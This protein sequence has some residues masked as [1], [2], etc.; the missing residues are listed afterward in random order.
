[1]NRDTRWTYALLAG[2]FLLI[3]LSAY[4]LLTQGRELRSARE[5]L[6]ATE[7]RLAQKQSQ[8]FV[9]NDALV[10]NLHAVEMLGQAARDV[11]EICAAQRPASGPGRS[12]CTL[13]KLSHGAAGR[14]LAAYARAT[15]LRASAESPSDFAAVKAEYIALRP[16][17]SPDLDPGRQWAA[18]VEEGVAYADYRLGNLDQAQQQVGNAAEI[19]DRSAFVRLT[20]LKIACAK[21]APATDVRRMYTTALR[22]LEESVASPR[23][24]MN[25]HYARLELGYFTQDP[26]LQFVCKYVGLPSAGQQVPTPSGLPSVD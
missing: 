14:F 4:M 19:D 11:E 17:L 22:S 7:R 21:G 20:A 13:A 3:C 1:M 23:R 2:S 5:N 26:E 6:E 24:G 8:L 18:R 25:Q 15:A 12:L 9:V 16:I 10:T